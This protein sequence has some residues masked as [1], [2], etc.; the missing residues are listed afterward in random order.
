MECGIVE[1]ERER[2]PS[3]WTVVDYVDTGGETPVR[4][5]VA[6][7]TPAEQSACSRLSYRWTENRTASR[8]QEG[9]EVQRQDSACGDRYRDRQDERL[10]RKGGYSMSKRSTP[11]GDDFM[12]WLEDL[13]ESH[14]EAKV[15]AAE[16]GVRLYLARAL[17][18][19][20][21]ASG[22]T[23]ADLAEESGLKQSMVSRL[24]R[25]DYNPTLQTVLKYVKAVNAELVLKVVVGQEEFAATP[26]SERS[27]VVPE[28]VAEQ[29][30]QRGVSTR[31]YVL[32]CIARQ[33][34]M[35][36]MRVI[37][38][39]EMQHQMASANDKRGDSE[40]LHLDRE[41]YPHDAH[42]VE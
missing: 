20:R 29:A 6:T 35:S 15:A 18:M 28:H 12:T 10:S 34:T 41:S 17:R 32:E 38:R 23:Q 9:R 7:L 5:F 16:E 14:P 11:S 4:A 24:E 31:E 40:I 21:E 26:V 36:E 25:S 39:Q 8:L 3:Q 1:F 22:M 2:L 42:E 37:I 13:V 30:K 19:A 33:S 27:V